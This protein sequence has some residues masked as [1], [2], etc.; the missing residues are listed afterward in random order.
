MPGWL[1]R[2]NQVFTLLLTA[3]LSSACAEQ[4]QRAAPVAG[5]TATAGARPGLA[6]TATITPVRSTFKPTNE[7]AAT[8]MP[9]PTAEPAS[10][11]EGAALVEALQ[12]GGYV[13]YFRHAAADPSGNGEDTQNLANCAGQRNLTEQ[14]RAEAGTIGAAFRTLEI[15]VGRVLSSAFCRARQTAQLAFG[16]TQIAVELTD[17][18]VDPGADGSAELAR[19]LSLPPQRGTNTV[20]VA[21]DYSL[22]AAAAISLGEG[23]AA[24]FAPLGADGFTL[25][26]RLL[27]QEW[28]GLAGLAANPAPGI[29]EMS[30]TPPAALGQAGPVES[31][32]PGATDAAAGA[33]S[34]TLLLPDLLTLPP[35]GLV[36]E[37][38]SAGNRKLLRLTNSVYNHGL[39]P[40][41]LSGVSDESSGK[42]SVT[43]RIYAA[44][45]SIEEQLAGEF[46][47][48]LGHDH[49]HFENFA[50]YEL[51]SLAPGGDLDSLV[52]FTGKVSYCLRDNTPA[53]DPASAP[54]PV[55]TSCD[56]DLQGIS[57]GWID[58]YEFDLAGQVVDIS[59]VPD[60][61]YALRSIADP[62][63][64]LRELDDAN[65][66]AMVYIQISA[67][68]VRI[69]EDAGELDDL[70]AGSE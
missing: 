60:G 37:V 50:R 61:V 65:N 19:L 28:A 40:L 33:G 11:L 63:N 46:V 42:T 6:A 13:I 43:Q 38:D 21:H 20:L 55:Y 44:G 12:R 31:I 17:L 32:S 18:P 47:F 16:K 4:T 58:I 48:H 5:P 51:W 36:I 56:G 57:T 30:A 27:P 64:Q 14:G 68:Q 3:L 45:G 53:G 15:P 39:G 70:L 9:S 34:A 66:A 35:S 52:A 62:D 10:A 41:E 67:D 8:V 49:W 29:S 1:I 26:G 22:A 69:I 23:E 24:I 59:S 25:V 2:A 54:V 7:S